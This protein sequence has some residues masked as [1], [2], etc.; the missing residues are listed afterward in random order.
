M[1]TLARF[2]SR[3]SEKPRASRV[4]IHHFLSPRTMHQRSGHGFFV[5]LCQPTMSTPSIANQDWRRFETC[6]YI[7]FAQLFIDALHLPARR[8]WSEKDCISRFNASAFI[9]CTDQWRRR[10]KCTGKLL[11]Q[12]KDDGKKKNFAPK[13]LRYPSPYLGTDTGGV[14]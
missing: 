5:L 8:K 11:I 4:M 3:N 2:W 13:W 14:D 6:A 10:G 12:G 9:S 7:L 1:L